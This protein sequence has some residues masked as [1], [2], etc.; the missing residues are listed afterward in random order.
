MLLMITFSNKSIFDYLILIRV[1]RAFMQLY[2]SI[3]NDLISHRILA[4]VYPGFFGQDFG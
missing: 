2:L 1:K 4:I 3:K